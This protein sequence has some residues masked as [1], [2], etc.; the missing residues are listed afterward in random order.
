M[1]R[2]EPSVEYH[3]TAP[4]QV[5]YRTKSRTTLVICV[6]ACSVNLVADARLKSKVR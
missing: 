3:T 5:H 4:A 6:L 1:D 2:R